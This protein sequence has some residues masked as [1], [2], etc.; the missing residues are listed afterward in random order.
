MNDATENPSTAPAPPLTMS[1]IQN[2][3]A[4]VIGGLKIE[5]LPPE[6]RDPVRVYLTSRSAC[7]SD[8]HCDFIEVLDANGWDF[9]RWGVAADPLHA[10]N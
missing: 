4:H 8:P 6:L 2:A 10:G 7:D 5:A 9:E 3:I 1:N